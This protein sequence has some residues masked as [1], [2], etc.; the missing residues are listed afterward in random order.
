MTEQVTPAG[1]GGAGTQT[2]N[3]SASATSAPQAGLGHARA[4][5]GSLVGLMIIA[6]VFTL[7]GTFQ[8]LFTSYVFTSWIFY[9][10]AVA[11]VMVLRRAKLE[12]YLPQTM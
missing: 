4:T 1:A 8:Q 2:S 3:L 7:V 10:L 12:P 9:G 6:A 5:G 11:A